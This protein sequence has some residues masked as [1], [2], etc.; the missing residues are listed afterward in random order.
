MNNISWNEKSPLLSCFDGKLQTY[1]SYALEEEK[2][3]SPPPPVLTASE[4]SFYQRSF[5][6][7][8]ACA[9]EGVLSL[10]EVQTCLDKGAEIQFQPYVIFR[11]N[12]SLLPSLANKV[13]LTYQSYWTT[14]LIEAAK[15]G[16]QPLV[17]SLLRHKSK[18]AQLFFR[19]RLWEQEKQFKLLQN[20]AFHECIWGMKPEEA[21]ENLQYLKKLME[22]SSYNSSFINLPGEYGYTPLHIA[23][24]KGLENIAEKLIEEGAEVNAFHADGL[25]PLSLALRIS[26]PNFKMAW[27]LLEKK[28]DLTLCQGIWTTKLHIG[29][30]IDLDSPSI[31]SLLS[32]TPPAQMRRPDTWG[33]TAEKLAKNRPDILHN[34]KQKTDTTKT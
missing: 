14:P 7:F 16:D 26:N 33:N 30:Y 3:T 32:N 31:V 2:R 23:A 28:A 18:G 5:Q 15:R 20:S 27:L 1:S 13:D 10:E 25:P 9:E 4:V 11:K 24:F 8:K 12:P 19:P 21:E 34:I 17:L 29:L 6:L 22:V